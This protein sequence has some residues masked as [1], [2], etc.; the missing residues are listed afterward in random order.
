MLGYLPLLGKN[1][2]HL[3]VYVLTLSNISGKEAH[4]NNDS[5]T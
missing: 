5:E 2:Q 4:V 1:R 3:I